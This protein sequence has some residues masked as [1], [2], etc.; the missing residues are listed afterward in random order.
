M[1]FFS[2]DGLFTSPSSV[3]FEFTSC[4]LLLDILSKC[5]LFF[6]FHSVFFF[7]FPSNHEFLRQVG[8]QQG[9]RCHLPTNERR[10]SHPSSSSSPPP[11]L[12]PP[13]RMTVNL[14]LERKG[15][16]RRKRSGPLGFFPR[17]KGIITFA[18][19][20]RGNKSSSKTLFFFL[21]EYLVKLLSA[22]TNFLFYDT[23]SCLA[24]WE[25]VFSESG[26]IMGASF[27]LAGRRRKEGEGM[28][29]QVALKERERKGGIPAWQN[30]AY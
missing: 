24:M 6:F 18:S 5:F 2:V 15:N 19:L 16:V 8:L 26:V 3:F 28:S 20:E 11:P 25:G 17:K 10:V 22:L 13:G 14:E 29:G 9:R 1:T 30:V 21:H 4:S 23:F 7:H 27:F 12:L